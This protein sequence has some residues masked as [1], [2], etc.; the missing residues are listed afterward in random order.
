MRRSNE[1]RPS[2]EKSREAADH[3]RHADIMRD[4]GDYDAENFAMGRARRAS[5]QA[6]R[7]RRQGN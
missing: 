2:V 3:R 5:T 6:E 1:T 4:I 7:L